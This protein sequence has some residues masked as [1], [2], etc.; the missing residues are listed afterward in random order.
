MTVIS[1]SNLGE[2]TFRANL[3]TCGEFHTS[4]G[5]RR[6]RKLKLSETERERESVCGGI[7][8]LC[9]HQWRYGSL[10]F[11][12]QQTRAR[13][14][15]ETEKVSGKAWNILQF[16]TLIVRFDWKYIIFWPIILLQ[17]NTTVKYETIF[18]KI[19]Y[20]KTNRA[21][22]EFWLSVVIRILLFELIW[23]GILSLDGV[24][25]YIG[26]IE[27]K[28]VFFQRELNKKK[29]L[30]NCIYFFRWCNFAKMMY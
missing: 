4:E 16:L 17:N 19:F 1:E 8:V 12:P 6:R 27:F 18:L 26:S 24:N 20:I 3:N 23:G 2:K 14:E 22:T 30:Q 15:G 25:I 10:G 5:F 28:L 9:C 29:V 13:R 11:R 21:L 7:V